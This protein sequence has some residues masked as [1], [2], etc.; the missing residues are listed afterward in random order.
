MLL[1]ARSG[2]CRV[3]I[4]KQVK[5]VGRIAIRP[6]SVFRGS[7]DSGLRN[8]EIINRNAVHGDDPALVISEVKHINRHEEPIL[9]RRW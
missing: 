7:F 5:D 6:Y 2:A 3:K 9:S 4:K 8:R 1:V